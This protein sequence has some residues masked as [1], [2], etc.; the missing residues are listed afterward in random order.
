MFP[1]SESSAEKSGFGD[2]AIL[3]TRSAKSSALITYFVC[4]ALY[5]A[6]SLVYSASLAWRAHDWS[7]GIPIVRQAF[8]VSRPGYTLHSIFFPA[9]SVRCI[10]FRPCLTQTLY[11][12]PYADSPTAV[13]AFKWTFTTASTLPR[14]TVA[15]LSGYFRFRS[16][17]LYVTGFTRCWVYSYFWRVSL[18]IYLLQGAQQSV[19]LPLVIFSLQSYIYFAVH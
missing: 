7:H 10:A 13:Q 11:Q 4:R 19:F 9:S 17:C 2:I 6:L 8:L 14:G 12:H 16:A 1:Q 5:S 18:K 3:Y 15:S